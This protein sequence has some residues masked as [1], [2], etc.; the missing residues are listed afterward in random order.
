MKYISRLLI[1]CL[2][3]VGCAPSEAVSPLP[4]PPNEAVEVKG[5]YDPGSSLEI[6]SLGA[7]R[8]YPL[9]PRTGKAILPFGDGI[10]LLSGGERTTLTLFTGDTL[11]PTARRHLDF[12]LETQSCAVHG[13]N[14][15]YYDPVNRQTVVLDQNLEEMTTIAAPAG[16]IGSPVLSPDGST[17]YYATASAIRAWD[18]DT[19]IHRIVRQDSANSRTVTALSFVGGYLRCQAEDRCFFLSPQTGQTLAEEDASLKLAVTEEGYLAAGWETNLWSLVFQD[20][21]EIKALTPKNLSSDYFLLGQSMSVVTAA[22]S[23]QVLTLDHYDLR[24]GRRTASQMVGGSAVQSVISANGELYLLVTLK[25]HLGQAIL[26][27][28]PDRSPVSDHRIYT[29]P[30]FTEETPDREG[31]AKCQQYAHQIGQRYGLN[32]LLWQE[33]A[34]LAPDGVTVKPEYRVNILMRELELL[35]DRL[36]RFPEG[37]LQATAQDFD[38][39]N[40]GLAAQLRG[41][42][43]EDGLHAFKGQKANLLL[44]V[45][46]ACEQALY[47]QLFHVMQTHILSH[48]SAFDQWDT[49][50]PAGFQYDR[51]YAANAIRNSGMYLTESNRYFVDTFSMSY[52]KEDQARI[53][54]CAMLED[55]EGVFRRNAMQKKLK[56]VCRGIREAY[57]LSAEE[58][59]PWERYR[60]E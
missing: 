5:L 11:V 48:S 52:P 15:S 16:L 10:L 35:D 43:R 60:K 50:N 6:S 30:H 53:F 45:G 26:R 14:L 17:L 58:T 20:G 38:C 56:A 27:W 42:I 18:P 49:L 44:A 9:S 25:D 55:N 1:L 21:G 29:G 24:T 4:S 39:L 22:S 41:G 47:H 59:Y 13:Q 51:D 8:V 19:G 23:G 28:E 46:G 2:L 34:A 54:E 31:L 12:S 40:I 33:A 7:I 36:S 57:R 3:L 32:I 37:L